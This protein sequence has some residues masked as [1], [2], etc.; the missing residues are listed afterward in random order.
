MSNSGDY[1]KSIGKLFEGMAKLA[2]TQTHAQ[3]EVV[4]IIN[5][6]CD[7]LESATDHIVKEISRAVTDI[8]RIRGEKVD[9]IQRCIGKQ[10]ERFSN[11]KLYKTLKT[12]KVCGDLRKLGKRFGNPLSSQ[13]MG[14]QSLI[15]WLRTLFKRSSR[16]QELLDRLYWDE[17]DYIGHF[18]T[19]LDKITKLCENAVNESDQRKLEKSAERI[20]GQ[21]RNTRNAMR[22]DVESLRNTAE[23]CIDS[24]P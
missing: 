22:M 9:T 1:M 13:S 20:K 11:E 2:K 8:N 5:D 23:Q 4:S 18:S 3:D 10:A 19:K 6:M 14:A 7:S 24:L 17:R 15:D 12:G 21:F 16:M